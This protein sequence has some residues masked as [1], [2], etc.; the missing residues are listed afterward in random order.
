MLVSGA[1]VVCAPIERA[2]PP[3]SGVEKKFFKN[4]EALF[5]ALVGFEA[6][7]DL[8]TVKGMSGGPV[9]GVCRVEDSVE[10]RLTGIQSTWVSGERLVRATPVSQ[11]RVA[12]GAIRAWLNANLA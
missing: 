4:T 2:F 1:N 12:L 5:G 10:Y 9:F 8:T 7:A 3:F 6:Q 11:I